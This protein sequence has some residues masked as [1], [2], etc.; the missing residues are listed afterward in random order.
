MDNVIN[1]A[2]NELIF[3][4]RETQIMIDRDLAAIYQ[5]NTKALN[6]AIKRNSRRFPPEFRFQLSRNELAELVT[7]CDRLAPL[8]HS[9]ALPY[10]F[11]EQGVAMLSAVLRSEVAI[12]TS[13]QIMHAFVEMRKQRI[14]MPSVIQRIESVELRQAMTENKMIS[15]LSALESKGEP[16]QGIFFQGQLFDAYSFSA[17]LIRKAKISIVL[18]DNYVDDRTFMLLSKRASGVKCSVYSRKSNRV[19]HDLDRHNNQYPAI[20]LFD[21]R[22]SHDRFIIIDDQFLYHF[23]ASLKDLGKNCFAFSMMNDLLP[24]IRERLLHTSESS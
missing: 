12:A 24:L 16:S 11:T 21:L 18:I 7:K 15:I 1:A 19:K 20:C 23:G 14:H 6:Q 4:M 22:E 2:I 13:I 5:V 9:N 3:M 17:D 10:A 8:K